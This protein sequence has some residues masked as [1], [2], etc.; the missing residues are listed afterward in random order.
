MMR[1]GSSREDCLRA[2][3]LHPLTRGK[4]D[5]KLERVWAWRQLDEVRG[6]WVL[7]INRRIG[8]PFMHQDPDD[9][10]WFVA[11]DHPGGLGDPDFQIWKAKNDAAIEA[12]RKKGLVYDDDDD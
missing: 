6:R 12:N 5:P 4:N 3:S 1:G 9:M 7:S 2:G 10:A 11:T 8:P